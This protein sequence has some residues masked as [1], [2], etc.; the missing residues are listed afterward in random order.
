MNDNKDTQNKQDNSEIVDVDFEDIA[1]HINGEPLFYTATQVAEKVD[2]EVTT[3]RFW[4]KR[5]NHLL[6]I[7]G[8]KYKKT[9]IA[10]L[11]FI[12]KLRR[13]DGLTIQQVDDYCSTKGFDIKDIENAIIDGS[14]PIAIQAFTRAV[15]TEVDKRIDNSLNA[16]FDRF[17]ELYNQS[18]TIQQ[19]IND[20]LQKEIT[21]TIEGMIDEKLN[22][23]HNK[24]EC[25]ID[26]LEKQQTEKFAKLSEDVRKSLEE[27]VEQGK[28][29]KKSHGLFNL[30]NWFK[31]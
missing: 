25:K 3:I 6:D 26:E 22:E 18:L 20:K 5:F 29:K 12:K 24:Y 11:L 13:E 19:D 14:N 9:D 23:S 28:E 21:T 2:E 30:K 8:K 10:K 31:K 7:E 1:K 27:R 4:A 15:M 16:F 17:K